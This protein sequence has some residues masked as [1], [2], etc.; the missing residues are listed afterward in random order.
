LFRADAWF[1][2][3]FRGNIIVFLFRLD[4]SFTNHEFSA[5]HSACPSS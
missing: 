3:N 4:I 2:A 1:S 5:E